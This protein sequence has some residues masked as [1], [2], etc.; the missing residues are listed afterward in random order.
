MERYTFETQLIGSSHHRERHD[1]YLAATVDADRAATAKELFDARQ[2]LLTEGQARAAAERSLAEAEGRIE[3]AVA[4]IGPAESIYHIDRERLRSILADP[5]KPSGARPEQHEQGRLGSTLCGMVA[6]LDGDNHQ[7]ARAS[8][9][10]TCPRCLDAMQPAAPRDLVHR[11]S[12]KSAFACGEKF[13][14][15]TNV[16]REVTCPEC[17]AKGAPTVAEQDNT[18]KCDNCTH[19]QGWHDSGTGCCQNACHCMRFVHQPAAMK[20]APDS[21]TAGALRRSME[22][23]PEMWRAAESACRTND[24]QPAPI[25]PELRATLDKTR[26]FVTGAANEHNAEFI[27]DQPA[28]SFAPCGGLTGAECEEV[29]RRIAIAIDSFLVR[30]YRGSQLR[31]RAGR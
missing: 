29:D 16:P 1:F 12:V 31:A 19:G 22:R 3:R 23:E 21:G 8:F 27:D 9:L 2:A 11:W 28:P 26:E 17:I 15:V 25:G 7:F 30:R 4:Y 5:A 10:V 6:P 24:G 13:G 18:P 14:I 20:P